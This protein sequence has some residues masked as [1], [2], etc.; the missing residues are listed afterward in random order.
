MISC[1]TLPGP[2]AMAEDEL[3]TVVVTASAAKESAF[4]VPPAEALLELQKTPGGVAVVAPESYLSGRAAT[5]EDSLKL[6][7]GVFTTS[8][9]GA[10]EARISIRGSG[11]QRTFHGRG[12]MLLQDGVPLN[13]ADG[14]FDMQAIEPQATRYIEIER[15]ANALRHG[16][17]TLGG[18]INYISETGLSA[19]KLSLRTEGGSFGYQRYNIASGAQSGRVDGYASLNYVEQDGFREHANQASWRF[20]GN[21]GVQVSDRIETRFYLTAVDTDSELPGNL[22]YAQLKADPRRA[23][24]RAAARDQHRDFTLYRFSNRTLITHSNGSSTDLS[25]YFAQKALYHPIEFFPTGPGL[26]EQ[27]TRDWGLGIRHLV[28]TNWLGHQQQNFVGVQWRH[29]LTL[30]ERFTYA[31]NTFVPGMGFAV[32]SAPGTL[33]NRQQQTADNVD[34]YGQSSWQLT[35]RTTG[36]MGL[37]STIARRRQAVLVDTTGFDP[38]TGAVR[39]PTGSYEETFQRTL[40][41][42]GLLYRASEAVE[43]YGN[44]SGSFEPPSFS[45]SLNNQP[46]RAQRA[47]T[48]ELGV[49]GN[50]QST[51]L[52]LG[53][54]LSLYRAAIR[55]EL[56]EIAL[57]AGQPATTNADHTVHQGVEAA[58]SAEA[59][60]WRVQATY[61][62][63]DFRFE[64]DPVFGRNQIAG[65]PDHVLNAE[66]AGRLPHDLW[67][68]PTLRASSRSYVDHANTTAAPGYTVYGLK[69]N[70]TLAQGLAWFV[71]G[72]NLT[73]KAYAATT[74]VV[75]DLTAAGAN[76]AQF[77]PG[78]GRSVFVGIS[79]AL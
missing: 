46:L 39:L 47:L 55:N 41:R 17:S 64:D 78:E 61:L 10:D 63:N 73:D 67:L 21:A 60:R 23:N 19:P 59:D 53:W 30:D 45:E 48:A 50:T 69:L 72:R 28:E 12:L 2:W 49:R 9:F 16:G 42:L 33:D 5:L 75:R 15:G 34:V 24:A 43:A 62:F 32:G 31:S 13:L 26:I 14:S 54:D 1:S 18:A 4:S 11:L 66:A 76:P 29:G 52:A 74:G 65:L 58:L 68:G 20:F 7:P 56:L 40:P 25:G 77:S 79:F 38:A 6:A 22:T 44:V 37:Q 71:E 36:V 57:N 51:A 70:Q 3:P 8:R 35:E 27:D